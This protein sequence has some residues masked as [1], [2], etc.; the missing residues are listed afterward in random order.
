[1]GRWSRDELEK[2]FKAYLETGARAAATG[3]WNAW[4]DQFTQ[5]A[6]YIEHHFGR[7]HGRE[8]IRAWITDVM[9][10]FP[11][12]SMD[13][14]PVPWYV[15]DEERGWIV[16]EIL[17]RMQDPGDGSIHEASNITILKYAGDNMWSSEEDVYN[18][19]KFMELIEKWSARKQELEKQRT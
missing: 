2:A 16:C 13:A 8:A 11:G 3:D 6:T 15:I 17:N 1:M 10:Q 18:P 9:S 5:D 14:F 19:M 12:N 4:A 7:F